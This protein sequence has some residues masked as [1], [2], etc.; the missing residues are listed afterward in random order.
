MS[1]YAKGKHAFGFCDR[2]GFR[3][4]LKDLVYEYEN[5]VLNGFRVGKDMV[6]KDHPQNHVGDIDTSDPQALLDPRPDTAIE[7]LFGWNPV[8]NPEEYMEMRS[9]TVT[10]TIS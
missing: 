6:D 3:Y 7:G 8:G 10:V 9:G 4:P 1:G 2:T 5:G